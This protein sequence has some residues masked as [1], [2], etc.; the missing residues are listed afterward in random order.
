MNLKKLL[1]SL[2]GYSR[3]ERVGSFVL[4]IVVAA[5]IVFRMLAI[6]KDDAGAEDS[7]YVIS[8]SAF[9]D[10][11][12]VYPLF[13]F[14]P[15]TV[16]YENLLK[17]GLSG[18]QANTLVNYRESGAVFFKPDDFRKVY[19]ISRGRQ[20]SLIPYIVINRRNTI[21]E[22]NVVSNINKTEPEKPYAGKRE[23]LFLPVEINSADSTQLISLPGI[24]EVLGPRIVKYRTLLGGF[25]NIMQLSEV[26]G[27][28]SACV[29]AM[30]VYISLDTALI[31]K[32]NLN[33]ADY[34]ELI[35]HPYITK[36]NTEDILNYRKYAGHISSL[37]E[38]LRN[39]ILSKGEIDKLNVYFSACDSVIIDQ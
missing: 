8:D 1:Y 26:Y 3:S 17:L 23:E 14:D 9:I 36:K 5:I 2:L 16:S 28:D 10:T 11:T 21:K 37:K 38:L 18:K 29:E 33:S 6:R 7:A 35:R 20:D 22:E 30:R 19:G 27:L 25:C 13:E 24:G 31:T 39:N 4:I 32:I 34:S 15:N 12:T